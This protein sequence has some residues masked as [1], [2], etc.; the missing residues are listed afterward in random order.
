MSRLLFIKTGYAI[1]G[2]PAEL[3]DFEHWTATAAGLPL[4]RCH[5]V[6]V[7]D[8]EPLPVASHYSGVVISGSAAMVTRREAWS[9]YTADWLRQSVQSG[10]PI[11][12]ICYGHQLLAQALGGRVDY[13]PGGREMGTAWIHRAPAAQ[14]D[15]LFAAM[16]ARFPAHVTHMQSVLGL[17]PGAE[18]LAW[19]S[20][21]AHHAVRFAP[22]VWGLQFHPEF[23]ALAMQ[24][25][26]R[27]RSDALRSEGQDPE[28]L[29]AAVQTTDAA[30][31]LLRRF[32]T[33]QR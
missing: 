14:H 10:V 6:T 8:G 28:A 7:I 23:T 1:P 12:G 20:F 11:L 32:V 9:E 4:E 30:S 3:G 17:P 21:E 33:L 5:V 27:L 18:V 25:Y 22:R 24:H 29:M 16:P 26:L 2:I 31:A 19:S 13:H 15:E